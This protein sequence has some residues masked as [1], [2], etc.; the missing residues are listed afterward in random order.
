MP[1]LGNELATQFQAF[2]TQTITG[3]GSTSYTLDRAV[4][5][6]KELLV[7][8][9]NVKQEEGSGKSYTATGTTIAFSAAVASTDSCY[10][11][12]LGSAVQTVNPPDASIGSS[13][14]TNATL[15][16]PNK[17]DMNG[18]ELILDAD[19]DTSITADTDDQID[20]KVGGSD[21]IRVDSSGRLLIGTT[22]EGLA[23]G[24]DLTVSNSGAVGITIRSTDSGQ[25]NLY[26][27]DATSGAGEY[28]GY[29]TYEHASDAMRFG[30]GGTQR[31][32]I[33][34]NGTVGISTDGSN[35]TTS[36][37]SGGGLVRGFTVQHDSATNF[38]AEFRSE[39]NNANRYGITIAYGADDN[40]SSTA[41]AISFLDGDGT[42]QGSITS[43]NGT[44]NYGAFTAN[45]D[46]YLPDADKQTGYPYGTLLECVGTT[47]KK[48]VGTGTTL[49]RGIQYNVQ[50][51]S[52]KGT[53]AVMGAYANRYSTFY[54][55]GDTIPEG[56][57]IGD[58][59]VVDKPLH[60]VYILGDG[61]ILCNNSGGNISIGDF[62]VASA[63]AGIGMKADASG[64][65]C[66]I[67]RE[68]I[69]FSSSSETKLV[70]VEYGLRQYIHS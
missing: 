27:S 55:H 28:A 1:Y 47:Y 53:N 65:A 56:K 2:V 58:E 32:R 36:G 11:V 30:T 12:F 57:V 68:N 33:N 70:A 41:I 39:G 26:F 8:I 63:T 69:S 4:A 42:S 34:S 7:Y 3:D 52:S 67:A 23:D 44:V 35:F 9:N 17:L 43:T 21:K 6:G 22:T 61:H 46:C 37:D 38:A 14:I 49:E 5:N 48:S 45:H 20:I 64:M 62:I 31:M 19:A 60:Q 66:G 13:Q 51:T 15:V 10:V 59:K 16:M 50:K 54:E 29:V 24:D 18:N 25:N 40:H